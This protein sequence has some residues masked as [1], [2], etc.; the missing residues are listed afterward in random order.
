MDESGL[1][2]VIGWQCV[3]SEAYVVGFEAN[4]FAGVGSGVI[5]ATF[6]PSPPN[7][8]IHPSSFTAL[9]PSLWQQITFETNMF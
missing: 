2:G 8:L 1:M 3:G 9:G 5:W 6:I 7:Q 4:G